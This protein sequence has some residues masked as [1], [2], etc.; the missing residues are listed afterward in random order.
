MGDLLPAVV[1][2]CIGVGLGVLALVM[3]LS[4]AIE[5]LI[6]RW[7]RRVGCPVCGAGPVRGVRGQAPVIDSERAGGG[8]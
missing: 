2:W 6:R 1:W 5:A 3:V 8:G 7:S 4:Q